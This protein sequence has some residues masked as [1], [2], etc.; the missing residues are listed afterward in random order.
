MLGSSGGE[1]EGP[2]PR[3]VGWWHA[4]REA[5][6]HGVH[7]GIEQIGPIVG[8]TGQGT[9]A[10]DEILV[11]GAVVAAHGDGLGIGQLALLEQIALAVGGPKCQ[12]GEDSQGHES[13]PGQEGPLRG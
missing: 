9:P 4:P 13:R 12:H 2:P 11:G 6:A 8:T 5:R 10:R 7:G 3:E 1:E